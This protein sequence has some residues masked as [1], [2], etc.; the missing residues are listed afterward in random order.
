MK[1]ARPQP[2]P[3]NAAMPTASPDPAGGAPGTVPAFSVFCHRSW[4]PSGDDGARI[5]VGA[6]VCPLS[7]IR[8][9]SS[10]LRSVK[11]EHGLKPDFEVKWTKVSPAKTG[12]YTALIDLFLRHDG[13]RFVGLIAESGEGVR[14]DGPASR[15]EI[16]AQLDRRLLAAILQ[17]PRRYRIYIAIE[18][19]RGGA[20][21]QSLRET[22]AIPPADAVPPSVER[23]QQIRARES[24]PLQLADLLT[25]ALAYANRG[26]DANTGK[27]AVVAR[28]RQRHA[29][30]ALTDPTDPTDSFTPPDPKF[31]ILT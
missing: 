13:L 28:L 1:P 27:A 10:S 21:L 19:T 17:G 30:G 16:R 25:G 18:D 29:Q 24:E 7:A 6:L 22:L 4:R 11:T 8:S 15:H 2:A 26:F 3:A 12:F 20:R 23:I 5:T 14:E 31:S 9:L